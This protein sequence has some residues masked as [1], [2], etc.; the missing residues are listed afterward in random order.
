MKKLITSSRRVADDDGPAPA[1]GERPSASTR[2]L[3]Q[4]LS[5]G[6][7]V[8]LLWR[9]ETDRVELSVRDVVTGSGFRIEVAAANAMD[10]FDHPYAYRAGRATTI[11]DD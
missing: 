3:A 1:T 2:E 5:G 4:R 9:P 10:A 11:A 6:D 8:L 7:E